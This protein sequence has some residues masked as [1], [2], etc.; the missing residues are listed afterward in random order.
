MI[1]VEDEYILYRDDLEYML[2]VEYEGVQYPL[3]DE[4][5]PIFERGAPMIEVKDAVVLSCWRDE[6]CIADYEMGPYP[7][8]QPPMT[9]KEVKE[10]EEYLCDRAG[11][12]V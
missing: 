8:L 10:F 6:T 11:P 1:R 2:T 3:D 12:D 4:G 7:P 9:E 5:C